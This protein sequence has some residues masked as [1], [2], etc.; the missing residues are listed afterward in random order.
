VA[1]TSGTKQTKWTTSEELVLVKA[2]IDVTEDPIVGNSQPRKAFYSRVG[3][4]FHEEIGVEE[5]YRNVDQ[6][7]SKWGSIKQ[8][9]AKFNGIVK[10][11][12]RNRPSGANDL[13]IEGM[14]TKRYKDEHNATAPPTEHWQILRRTPKFQEL[15]EDKKVA[16]KKVLIRNVE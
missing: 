9:V 2:V 7:S 5:E 16:S 1:S 4:K 6:L 11:I 13:D 14:A 3:E 15:I 10:G 8:K 12:L